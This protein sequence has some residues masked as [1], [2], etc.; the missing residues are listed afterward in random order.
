MDNDN[1]KQ[2]TI[3]H[4]ATIFIEAMN[5]T[6]DPIELCMMWEFIA[7]NLDVT[8]I[9][10]VHSGV[11]EKLTGMLT[12][13]VVE[14]YLQTASRKQIIDIRLTQLVVYGRPLTKEESIVSAMSDGTIPW[15]S[16]LHLLRKTIDQGVNGEFVSSIMIKLQMLRETTEGG[17]P[18]PM[19]SDA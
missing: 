5:Q 12:S 14:T 3:S 10:Q 16:G 4:Q 17:G 1:T 13:N 18:P 15:T 8:T 9:A 7:A 19:D 11:K 2:T 6:D